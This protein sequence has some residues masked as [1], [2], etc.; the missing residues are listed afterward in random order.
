MRGRYLIRSPRAAL[1]LTAV[2]LLLRLVPASKPVNLAKPR[3]ILLS[4]WGH[5]GDVV[6][7]FGAIRALRRRI[8]G[9]RIGMLVG[10]WAAKAISD[11]KL[12]D[13]IHIVDHWAINRSRASLRRKKS[14][15]REMRSSALSEIKSFGYDTAIDFYPFFPPAHVLFF[16]AHIPAR[17]G[18]DSGGFGP[19][20]N[21]PVR[22]VDEDRPVSDY[23]R[24]L[25]NVVFSD[26]PLR[27]GELDP[28]LAFDG[29]PAWPS[30]MPAD[31]PY[32]VLHPGAG[33]PF[34][35]WGAKNWFMLADLFRSFRPSFRL[36]VT[37]AGDAEEGVARDMQEHTPAVIN[38]AGKLSLADFTSVVAH[39][40]LLICPDTAA[41]H[42][43]GLFRTPTVCLFTGTNNRWQWSPPNP[44]I[45][46]LTYPVP[47][48]P[49]NRPGCIY[50]SCLLN[51]LPAHV[52]EAAQSLLDQNEG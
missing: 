38:L 13:N 48:A 40:K 42:I 45:R 41:S 12:V 31:T 21:Y 23:H 4:N 8:P 35:D 51:I 18:F 37:G 25:L 47:C 44:H 29:K 28:A 52:F 43:A 30:V 7:T 24:D 17:I 22:W 39:A 26:D 15:Y 2:D 46:V 16:R 1:M 14:K 36:V 5:I 49:C 32:I 11:S 34:K 33:A 20:L 10:S 9:I 27:F 50:M 6:T 3:H 19:L